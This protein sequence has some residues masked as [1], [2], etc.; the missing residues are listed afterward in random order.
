MTIRFKIWR[1]YFDITLFKLK[2][3]VVSKKKRQ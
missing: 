3:I 2:I 1:L